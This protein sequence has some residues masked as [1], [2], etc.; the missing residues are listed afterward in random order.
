MTERQRNLNQQQRSNPQGSDAD[1]GDDG[2][3][4]GMRANASRLLGIADDAFERIRSEDSLD[5]V[6]RH[7]QRGGQ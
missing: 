4:A 7:R 5:H 3:L 6:F 2:E 1:P